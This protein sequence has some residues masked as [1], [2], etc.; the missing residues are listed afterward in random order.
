MLVRRVLIKVCKLLSLNLPEVVDWEL[1][2][3]D[4]I[5]WIAL[6]QMVRWGKVESWEREN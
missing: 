1:R 2:M 5:L 3:I 4:R 6:C